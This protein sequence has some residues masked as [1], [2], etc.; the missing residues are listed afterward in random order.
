MDGFL[1]HPFSG[2]KTDWRSSGN[3]NPMSKKDPEL[4]KQVRVN[5][6]VTDDTIISMIGLLTTGRL[7][8]KTIME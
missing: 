4:K 3:I 7:K 2:Q 6:T 1:V 5:F 8:M